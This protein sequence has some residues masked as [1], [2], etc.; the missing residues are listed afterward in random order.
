MFLAQVAAE[1]ISMLQALW[2]GIIEGVTEFLPISSTG[3]LLVSSQMLGAAN[4]AGTFEIVI[5]LG[6]IIAVVIYYWK[7]LWAKMADVKTNKR[8]QEFWIRLF[9]AFLP[10]AVVGLLLHHWIDSLL[11][12]R[13]VQAYVIGG[14]LIIGGIVLWWVD[15][16]TAAKNK[17]LSQS[18]D[19]SGEDNPAAAKA[20]HD[21]EN[22]TLRQSLWIGFAQCFALIPGMSRSGATIVGALLVGL[23]RAK[24]TE[25]SFFLSI[26]TLGAATLYTLVKNFSKL[27]E[28][29]SVGALGLGTVAAFI[30]AWLSID[31]LLRYVSSNDFRGFAVYRVAVGLLIIAWA[32]WYL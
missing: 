6:A 23:N 17:N 30:T 14:T 31:W 8:S 18:L 5:Q 10:A 19:D 12:N 32:N 26:P 28:V 22:I 16:Y 21:E 20:L 3:H 15:S 4:T 24:A 25:F 2:L 13:V 1:R 9:I 11:E 7:R 27:V 29:G